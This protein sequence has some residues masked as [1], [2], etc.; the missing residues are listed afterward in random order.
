[1]ASK[2][3]SK[4]RS[5]RQKLKA[6]YAK[7]REDAQLADLIHTEPAG[8]VRDERV[9]PA[10]QGSAILPD[11]VREALRNNWATPD[12]AKPA[13]V[14]SLLEPFFAEREVGLDG[15][16]IPPN[17]AQTVELAK[18]LRLLDQTQFERDHPEEAGTAKGGT[19][20]SLQNTL[21]ATE[22][23]RDSLGDVD[24]I[25]ELTKRCF[26]QPSSVQ[27]EQVPVDALPQ[28]ES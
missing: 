16:P 17:R 15:K 21:Q 13:I 6:R 11:L 4:R 12:I 7:V 18:V 24:D 23:M 26:E 2:P 19:H 20:I 10:L 22:V 8:A 14:A 1:M 3:T 28:K 25:M 9:N 5:D 27:V